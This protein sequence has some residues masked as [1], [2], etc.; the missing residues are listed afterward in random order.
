MALNDSLV[1]G[2]IVAA[3]LYTSS[4]LQQHSFYNFWTW[5]F[6]CYSGKVSFGIYCLH[7]WG[8]SIVQLIIPKYKF[9][10][11]VIWSTVITLCLSTLTF[12]LIEEPGMKLGTYLCC[13][14]KMFSGFQYACFEGERRHFGLK[15]G[16]LCWKRKPLE[17]LYQALNSVVK[18]V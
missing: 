13:K 4:V 5:S 8:I 2:I 14:V 11:G 7:Q 12:Y 10:E 18:E 1:S 6:W 17:T 15:F 3:L 9:D 16:I